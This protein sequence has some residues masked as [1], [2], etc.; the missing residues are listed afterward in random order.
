MV[1][2]KK[3]AKQKRTAS[4][5]LVCTHAYGDYSTTVAAP[6]TRT[7]PSLERSGGQSARE[8]ATQWQPPQQLGRLLGLS[9]GARACFD[10]LVCCSCVYW[11]F[12]QILVGSDGNEAAL[13][14]KAHR[15]CEF[16]HCA[17]HTMSSAP[18]LV[19]TSHSKTTNLH[20]HYPISSLAFR[21]CQMESSLF[22]WLHVT[23]NASEADRCA[24]E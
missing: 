12:V 24:H 10:C 6:G 8:E 14:Q 15:C 20:L 22:Q 3:A 23:D 16:L 7:S 9:G 1:G 4:P 5:D 13:A 18:R 17:H 2:N 21:R 19:T 11:S